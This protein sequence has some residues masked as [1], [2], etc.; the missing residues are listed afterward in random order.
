M[1]VFIVGDASEP[2][3]TLI[4]FDPDEVR[5]RGY[6]FGLFNDVVNDALRCAAFGFTAVGFSSVT[7]VTVTIGAIRLD[8]S[9][10]LAAARQLGDFL[11]ASKGC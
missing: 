1:G 9:D 10:L 4:V 5:L 3:P 8:L 6:G 11:Y 7:G 2:N